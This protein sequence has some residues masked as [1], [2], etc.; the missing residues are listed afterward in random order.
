MQT[1]QLHPIPRKNI[2]YQNGVAAFLLKQKMRAA[3]DMRSISDFTLGSQADVIDAHMA[4]ETTYWLYGAVE[5]IPESR[6]LEQQIVSCQG[7]AVL[8]SCH[9]EVGTTPG[10]D[11]VMTPSQDSH[12]T[13][14][15]AK[16]RL[17]VRFPKV[18]VG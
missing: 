7:R 11:G 14:T 17:P 8:T 9:L 2:W 10:D 6:R 15:A 1:S 16:K 3:I 18:T 5:I 13:R 12:F 4:K